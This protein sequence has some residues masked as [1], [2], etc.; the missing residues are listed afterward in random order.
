[1]KGKSRSVTTYKAKLFAFTTIAA[2]TTSNTT[3]VSLV[4][5]VALTNL[6]KCFQYYRFTKLRVTIPPPDYPESSFNDTGNGL[7]GVGYLSEETVSTVTTIPIGATLAL[8]NSRLIKAS[9]NNATASITGYTV[10]TVLNVPRRALLSAPVKWYKTNSASA[11]EVLIQQGTLIASVATAPLSNMEIG[12]FIDFA[13]EF[14]MP[15][16]ATNIV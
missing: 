11:E 6:G 10:P 15:V 13:V 3:P 14:C 12:Y 7:V 16:D 2:S 1:M 9:Q 4:L 8:A 5:S